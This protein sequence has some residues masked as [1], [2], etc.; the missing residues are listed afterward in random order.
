[1]KLKLFRGFWQ[2]V[3]YKS[4]E[5][6]LSGFFLCMVVVKFDLQGKYWNGLFTWG[7]IIYCIKLYY[8]IWLWSGYKCSK[9][10]CDIKGCI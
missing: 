6:C 2:H 3:I 10:I 7:D 5:L 4:R 9:L 1:M 8:Q